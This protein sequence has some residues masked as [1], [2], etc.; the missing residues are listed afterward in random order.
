[1]PTYGYSVK[2]DP[3]KTAIASA[4][5]VPVK[6]KHVVNVCKAIKGMSLE[7]AKAFLE[8]V[9]ELETAVPF[10]RHKRKVAHRRGKVGPGQ[11]PVKA[12]GKVLEVVKGAEANAEYKGLDPE[13]MVVSHA[14]CQ[15]A[16]PIQGTMQRAHGRA[17]PWNTATCHIEI[18]L[19]EKSEKEEEK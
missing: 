18:V 4:R 3:E 2:P 11:F 13:K 12:A 15:R 7:R 17:T 6:P 19:S 14:A 9:Q 16:A 5:E 8:E 1:M 10:V